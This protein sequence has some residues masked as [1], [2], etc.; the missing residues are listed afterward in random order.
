MIRTINERRSVVANNQQD[1]LFTRKV[2]AGKRTYHF[3]VKQSGRGDIYIVIHEVIVEGGSP[4]HH[5]VVVY[6]DHIEEFQS[7]LAEAA[8][9]VRGLVKARAGE[10][11][12][13]EEEED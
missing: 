2:L 11:N 9:Y 3:N 7:G 13:E 8:S 5:R 10:E 1:E 6:E 12:G 4:Q